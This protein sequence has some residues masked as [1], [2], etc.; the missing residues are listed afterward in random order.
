[1]DGRFD[2]HDGGTPEREWT[3]AGLAGLPLI[4]LPDTIERLLVVVA[5]PDDE[6]LGA[7]G[8]IAMAATRGVAT[9]VVVASNGEASHPNSPTHSATRLAEIRRVEVTQAV[10]ELHPGAEL[11][12]LGRPDSGLS[13]HVDEISDAI[14]RHV[15]ATTLLVTPWSGDRHPDHQACADAATVVTQRTGI[16]HWQFPIWAWHWATPNSPEFPLGRLR[17]LPLDDAAIAA[18]TRALAEHVSQHTSL[19][20]APGDEVLLHPS[21]LAHFQRSYEVFVVEEPARLP[22]PSSSR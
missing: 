14:D 16:E 5:H 7:G 2:S 9:T 11:H 20:P 4:E 22:R 3:A 8:L 1:M 13:A 19:S 15:D 10:H 17:C 12:L 21:M 18:K 6:T